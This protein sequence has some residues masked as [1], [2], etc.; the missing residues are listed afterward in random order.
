MGKAAAAAAAGLAF[1]PI[2]D[3]KSK[4]KGTASASTLSGSGLVTPINST[5]VTP[6]S[7]GQFSVSGTMG[8]QGLF[9]TGI[10]EGGT[11]NAMQIDSDRGNDWEWWTMVM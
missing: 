2:V 9:E 6:P 8:Q 11:P 1:T 5:E 3:E 7:N 10:F 4:R